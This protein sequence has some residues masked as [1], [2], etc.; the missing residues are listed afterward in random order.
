M[1]LNEAA[2]YAAVAVTALATG[3]I[4]DRAG[5]R[6]EPFFLGL[7]YAGLGLALSTLFV[8]ETRGHAAREAEVGSGNWATGA[9]A[10]STREVFLLTSFRERALS[11]CS[12]AGMVNYLND[13][14][15]L[16]YFPWFLDRYGNSILW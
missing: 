9:G 6:P 12:Q 4:A 13:G 1:G 15:A 14:I 10:L 7:S 3:Y 5:L 2:G 16:G 8:R 11:A